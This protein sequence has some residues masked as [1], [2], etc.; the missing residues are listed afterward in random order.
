MLYLPGG[1]RS[2]GK[3]KLPFSSLTTVTATVVPSFLALTRTP[4]M[5]PSSAEETTPVRAG[6]LWA[7]ALTGSPACT[8]RAP[9]PTLASIQSFLS[10]IV[11]LP[12]LVRRLLAE[13]D[14][15]RPAH[16]HPG[17]MDRSKSPELDMNCIARSRGCASIGLSDQRD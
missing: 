16:T 13:I 8:S 5:L 12:R 4:S 9:I 10:R 14:C 1:R 11:H 7:W 17:A 6:P 2:A 3:A 15:I